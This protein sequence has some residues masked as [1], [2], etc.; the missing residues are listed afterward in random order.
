MLQRAFRTGLAALL[1]AAPFAGAPVI[2]AHAEAKK[3]AKAAKPAKK[4]KDPI[5][6]KVNGTVVRL[7]DVQAERSVLPPRQRAL[8]MR[9]VFRPLL[10]QIINRK[11]F[12]LAG[13]KEK[14]QDDPI[15]KSELARIEDRLIQRAYITA[16]VEKQVT[17]KT[18]KARYEKFIK[19]R[20]AAQ[21][22][23]ARHILVKSEREAK[24]IIAQL[25][26]G[27]DFAKLASQKSQGPSKTRGGDL[28]WFSKGEMVKEFDAVVFKLKKGQVSA[29]P[30]KTQFGW[31][32]IKV[33][34][35]RQKKPPTFKEARPRLAN[36]M[37]REVVLAELKKLRKGSKVVRY[38][39]DGS[40]RAARGGGRSGAITT[41]P[42]LQGRPP[43][44]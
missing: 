28:G 12:A 20:K 13:R 17:D 1:V 15:V 5:V 37:I 34:E 7:S 21:E 4:A 6:A 24:A 19:E 10:E 25:K 23:R 11:L 26:K 27:G 30:V 2:G 18:V 3:P 38:N 36:R 35:I 44:K 42:A 32:V 43:A 39:A 22:V 9:V 29:K 14:L 31:H 40:P 16:R 33:E 41:Y 8:P